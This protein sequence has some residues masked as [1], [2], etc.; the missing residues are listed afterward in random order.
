MRHLRVAAGRAAGLVRADIPD[1]QQH[2]F[3]VVDRAVYV[4]D[5][6]FRVHLQQARRYVHRQGVV[7]FKLRDTTH[8][9][10]DS[11]RRSIRKGNAA[12]VSVRVVFSPTAHDLPAAHK[13]AVYR[14]RKVQKFLSQPFHVAEVFTGQAGKYVPVS[15][16]VRG[17]RMIVDGELD[18]CPESAFFMAGTIDEVI[19]RA[20][21]EADV[22]G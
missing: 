2:G 14:A 16:T 21:S 9:G 11:L 6:D 20:K 17:F 1:R 13:L 10:Y 12:G 5:I 22:N 15:E 19:E 3:R 18:D 8:K 4:P 7:V